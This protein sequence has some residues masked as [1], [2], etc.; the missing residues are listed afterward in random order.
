MTDNGPS[1]ERPID[2][3]PRVRDAGRFI[4]YS[5]IA[6]FAGGCY[7][8]YRAW[9]GTEPG[10]SALMAMLM[11][12]AAMAVWSPNQRNGEEHPSDR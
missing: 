12:M 1:F 10:L 9:A 2:R 8:V 4:V 5:G 7:F 6:P 3:Y 11:G